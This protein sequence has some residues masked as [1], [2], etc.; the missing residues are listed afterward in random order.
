[1]QSFSKGQALKNG[2]LTICVKCLYD[3]DNQ[4]PGNEADSLSLTS[5]STAAH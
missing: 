3:S 2:W 5:C 1:M 4:L